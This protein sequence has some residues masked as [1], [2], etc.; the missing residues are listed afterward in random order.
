M[1]HALTT[2]IVIKLQNLAQER[3]ALRGDRH[4][5]DWQINNPSSSAAAAQRH[6]GM[7]RKRTSPWLAAHQQDMAEAQLVRWRKSKSSLVN[8][9]LTAISMSARGV[10]ANGKRAPLRPS[11]RCRQ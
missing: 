11:L 2:V 5:D 7:A 4:R 3:T 1:Y 6:S 8:S 10:V 9:R